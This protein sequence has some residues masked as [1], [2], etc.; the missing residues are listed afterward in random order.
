MGL[1]H[2]A[3]IDGEIDT[4]PFA[5]ALLAASRESGDVIPPTATANVTP[6][7]IRT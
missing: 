7:P 1:V 6:E 5:P 4:D 3:D 2:T